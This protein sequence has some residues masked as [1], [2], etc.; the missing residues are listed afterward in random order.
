M[1]WGHVVVPFVALLSSC[2]CL[3]QDNR[4]APDPTLR[5]FTQATRDGR[6]TDAEKILTDAIH[7]LE[8]SDPQNPRLATYLLRLSTVLVRRGDRP[9]ADA[10][11]ERAYEIDRKAYGPADMRITLDLIQQAFF[12]QSSGDDAKAERLLNDALVVVRSNSANLNSQ[13]NIGLAAGV[14]GSLAILYMHE[15]RWIEAEPMLKEEAKLCGLIEEP[16]RAGYADCGHL[17]K[18]FAEVSDAEGKTAD[19]S[20]LPHVGDFPQ[21][22][23]GLNKAGK[24]FETDGLYPSSEDAYNRAIALAEKLEADPQNRYG[25]LI[26]AE[27]N[28]LGQVYEKEGL[29]DRA[30]RTYLNALEID[31]NKAGPDLGHTVYAVTLAPFYLVDLYRSEGRLSDAESLLQRVLEIQVRSL[32]E[33]NRAVVQT[34]TTLALVYVEEGKADETKY[35]LA[36]PLYERA[37]AS[38]E[39]NLGPQDRGLLPLLEEYAELLVKL[40]NDSK[41]AEV[42]ARMAGISSAEQ[43]NS[44]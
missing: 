39:V 4:P 44:K 23:E 13:S 33:R 8:Q 15:H 12:S 41:A 6:L 7:D 18:S 1:K 3:A 29:K 42:R 27:M 16:Y 5:A 20:Q 32:G 22:L 9:E 36:Q 43:N 17:A 2:V 19:T 31:E 10:L 35:A 24:Q 40:H 37:L 21:E 25:G 34:L 28:F 26:V 11:M 38:Q 14:V 30:E